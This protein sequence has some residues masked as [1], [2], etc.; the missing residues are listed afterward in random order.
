MFAAWKTSLLTEYL[1]LANKGRLLITLADV[2][3]VVVD[4]AFAL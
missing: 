4:T 1:Y 2:E 3:S